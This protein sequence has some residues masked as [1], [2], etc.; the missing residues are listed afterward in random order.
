MNRQVEMTVSPNGYS[1]HF[2]TQNPKT[3]RAQ[4]GLIFSLG[5][6]FNY[7]RGS[8]NGMWFAQH[9]DIKVYETEAAYGSY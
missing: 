2:R 6:C 8:G 5:R 9:Q 7:L 3:A 4:R 1:V